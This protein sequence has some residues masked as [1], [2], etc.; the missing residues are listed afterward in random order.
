[1][2]KHAGLYVKAKKE[3]KIHLLRLNKREKVK[4]NI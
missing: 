4:S 3:H 2:I 1:M